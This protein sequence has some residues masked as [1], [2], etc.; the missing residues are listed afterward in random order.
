MVGFYPILSIYR[1][2]IAL[3]DIIDISWPIIDMGEVWDSD[4]R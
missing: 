4:N 3:S 1:D 2:I